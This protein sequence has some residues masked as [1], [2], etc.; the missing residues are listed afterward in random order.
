LYTVEG[1]IRSVGAFA[2]GLKNK[3]PRVAAYRRSMRRTAL[4]FVAIAILIGA[5][6]AA[7]AALV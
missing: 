4:G 7:I 6:V 3:D 1:R 2:R 5:V